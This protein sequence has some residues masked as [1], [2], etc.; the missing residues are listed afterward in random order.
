MNENY[1][2]IGPHL[3]QR[4]Y[5]SGSGDWV[6]LYYAR[7]RDRLKKKPRTFPVGS[8]ERKAKDE[9]RRLETKDIDLYD[10]DQDRKRSQKETRRDGKS[11][12]FTFSEWCEL[13]RT[14]DDVKRKRS[15]P[16]DLTLIRL[17][18]KPFFGPMLLTEITREGLRRYVDAR[19]KATVIRSGNPSKKAVHRG[20]VSNELSLLRR[21][22]RI[23]SREEYKVI[24]PS[25]LDLIVRTDH[26][27]RAL[28]MDERSKVLPVFSLWIR[29]L[30]EFAIETCLSLSD[31]LRLTESMIDE[32]AGVVTPDGGRR[33]TGVK[34]ISPL[35]KRA[36]E[37]I[38]EIREEKRNGCIVPNV[39]GLIFTNPDGTPI[40]KG[41]VEYQVERAIGLTGTKKF[42]F[43]NL[44]NTALTEWARRGVPV[45]VAML[46]SGHSSVQMHK[47]YLDLQ[48]EDIAA[49]FGTSKIATRIATRKHAGSSK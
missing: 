27:G 28:T 38:N 18:L 45:D 24:V 33:K 41:R 49:A 12:P 20:T 37:I 25:F 3:F 47:R 42:V 9:L 23:A 15:L 16:T 40:T 6:T 22:L 39:K 31:L 26:G 7:F 34:Q 44:R 29:R 19:M 13:Y 32:K 35:T 43:H 11:E 14:F 10:F 4:Q 21:M 46:A 8:D 30:A 2:R 36:R 17:H 48:K 5:Q 1:K